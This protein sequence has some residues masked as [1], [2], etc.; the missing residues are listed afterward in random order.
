MLVKKTVNGR[1]KFHFRLIL[2]AILR[3][4]RHQMLR[5][6][7]DKEI[8]FVTVD[9]LKK[10]VAEEKPDAESKKII[11]EKI[12]KLLNPP[13]MNTEEAKKVEENENE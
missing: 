4:K 11:E 7:L 12:D 8:S 13:M 2:S 5:R 10:V 1:P 3:Y 6:A 9:Y